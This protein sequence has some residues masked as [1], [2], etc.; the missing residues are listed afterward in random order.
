MDT[1]VGVVGDTG[2]DGLEIITTDGTL[3]TRLKVIPEEQGEDPFHL[4]LNEDLSTD[5]YLLFDIVEEEEQIRFYFDQATA[6]AYYDSLQPIPMTEAMLSDKIFYTVNDHGD[7]SYDFEEISFISSTEV[8]FR[9]VYIDQDG[10]IAY[11]SSVNL[12]YIIED[13]NIVMDFSTP[14]DSSYFIYELISMTDTQWNMTRNGDADSAYSTWLLTAPSGFP[15][16]NTTPEPTIAITEA[17]LS[18]QAFY[19]EDYNTN[20]VGDII[21]NIYATMTFTATEFTR[22]EIGLSAANETEVDFDESSTLPY[23]LI[24]GKI[25]LDVSLF[26]EGYMWFTLI[27][28]SADTWYLAKE[29]DQDQDGVIDVVDSGTATWYLSKPADFPDFTVLPDLETLLVG[30][31]FYQRVQDI[32]QTPTAEWIAELTFNANGTS[33][34][35]DDG[36][37]ETKDYIIDGNTIALTDIDGTKVYTLTDVTDTYI[38]FNSSIGGTWYFTS[39]DAA[40]ATPLIWD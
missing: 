37:P 20:D 4:V 25:R 32:T 8:G 9:E 21:T 35:V 13:G 24:D 7:G 1:I 2:T 38:E 39:E 34:T 26:E 12:P 18:G 23:T 27:T 19:D 17:M 14:G 16:P 30:N 31:T 36:Q 28:E 11:E 22:H 15:E 6:E 33:V 3:I 40:T 5:D 10:S 29:K